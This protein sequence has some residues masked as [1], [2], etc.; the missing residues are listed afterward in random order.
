MEEFYKILETNNN[1]KDLYE[2]Y[3]KNKQEIQ[4]VFLLD[5]N[6]IINIEFNLLETNIVSLTLYKKVVNKYCNFIDNFFESNKKIN[7]NN[8]KNTIIEIITFLIMKENIMK[9]IIN[10]PEHY[11]FFYKNG[12][13]LYDENLILTHCWKRT[14]KNLY[15]ILVKNL[16]H[17]KI[18][19]DLTNNN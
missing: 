9:Y 5:K 15:K 13:H 6:N 14:N 2:C 10:I 16:V 19:I 1:I 3:N 12:L 11:E 17:Y 18:K 7:E 8:I 4:T